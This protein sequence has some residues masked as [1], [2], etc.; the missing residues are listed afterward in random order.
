M[1]NAPPIPSTI[2]LS[3]L[4]SDFLSNRALAITPAERPSASE[5]LRH[6]FLAVEDGWSWARDSALA[7]KV[8]GADAEVTSGGGAGGAAGG[9][10]GRRRRAAAA[11]AGEE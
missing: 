7:R 4:A 11:A 5:A 2:S 1:G 6:P 3:P 9:G 10:K 8:M